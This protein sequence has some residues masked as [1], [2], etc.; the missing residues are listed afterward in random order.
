MAMMEPVNVSTDVVPVFLPRRTRWVMGL[1]LG[2]SSDPTAISVLEHIN[3]VL[4][5]N[6]EWER[7]CGIGSIPQVKAER[8][9]V[10]HLERLPLG[11]SYPAIVQHVKDLLA[12]PPLSAAAELVIDSTG[13]G[14]AVADI[15]VAAG[16]RPQQV[17]ITAGSDISCVGDDRWHVSKTHLISVV[18]AMLHTGVLRFAAQLTEAPAMKDELKD[19]RRKLS[20]A[21]RATYAARTGQHDDLVLS[22][23]IACWWI[24]QPQDEAPKFGTYSS[25]GIIWDSP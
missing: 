19:F 6:P 24:S 12:R 14:R 25:Q 4:D 8:V 3:G 17:T 15:F 5:S 2:Q 21:G 22:V 20:D 1:D 18:D 10:R 23:A 11:T 16:L 7:H 13:V 9:N